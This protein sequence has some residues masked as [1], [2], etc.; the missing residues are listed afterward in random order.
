M[1]QDDRQTVGGRPRRNMHPVIST[2]GP[3][4]PLGEYAGMA[5]EGFKTK[6]PKVSFSDESKV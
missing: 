1:D 2:A 5:Q 6:P 4:R 3:T